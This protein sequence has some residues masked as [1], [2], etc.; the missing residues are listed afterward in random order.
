MEDSQK[1]NIYD[2]FVRYFLIHG[3]LTTLAVVAAIPVGLYMMCIDPVEKARMEP[4]LYAP[5]EICS[6][7]LAMLTFHFG[8]HLG[9]FFPIIQLISF[10]LNSALLAFIACRLRYMIIMQ[11][12]NRTLRSTE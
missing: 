6:F 10:P 3:L 7:P 9:P 2:N 12:R 8:P 11:E 5:I 4:A 1:P